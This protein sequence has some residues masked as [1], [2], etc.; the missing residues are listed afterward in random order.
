MQKKNVFFVIDQK[1]YNVDQH[2]L[3]GYSIISTVSDRNRVIL[4]L[5]LSKESQLNVKL[6]KAIALLKRWDDVMAGSE[7]V[8]KL[9]N[10]TNNFLK[11]NL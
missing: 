8:F 2:S 6:D 11:E 10:D 1:V 5:D 9:G 4:H 7:G 3:V